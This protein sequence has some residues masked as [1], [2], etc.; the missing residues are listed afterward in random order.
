MGLSTEKP[1]GAKWSPVEIAFVKVYYRCHDTGWIAR[2]LGRQP[3]S[4]RVKANG[5]DLRKAPHRDM[6]FNKY[7]KSGAFRDFKRKFKK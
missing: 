7:G 1:I 6:W 3:V 5:N 4:V 2:Q